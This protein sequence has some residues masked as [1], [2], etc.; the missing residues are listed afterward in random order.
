[1]K[2]ELRF[3]SRH[4]GGERPVAVWMSVLLHLT[5]FR[6]TLQIAADLPRLAPLSM[7]VPHYVAAARDLAL[8]SRLH[9]VLHGGDFREGEQSSHRKSPR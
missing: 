8:F 9:D 3:G 7:A 6:S 5:H 2:S 4:G 1:M